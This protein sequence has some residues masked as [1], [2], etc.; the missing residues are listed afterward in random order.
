MIYIDK[1]NIIHIKFDHYN[2]YVI[3]V[4]HVSKITMHESTKIKVYSSIILTIKVIVY[5]EMFVI[6]PLI[7]IY[8]VIYL[9]SVPHILVYIILW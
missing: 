6:S 4:S 8:I 3:V 9:Q 7:L 2:Y 1:A 5:F